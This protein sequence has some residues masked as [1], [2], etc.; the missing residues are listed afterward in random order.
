MAFFKQ[1]NCYSKITSVRKNLHLSK[2]FKNKKLLAAENV[3]NILAFD[4][5]SKR[6][7]LSHISADSFI[8]NNIAY[9]FRVE[10]SFMSKWK[11]FW[12]Q[13]NFIQI[14][15]IFSSNKSTL[16]RL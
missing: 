8:K 15:W 3:G 11:T 7:L 14:L 6:K 2:S 16:V 13:K 1:E 12:F 5:E 9:S 10:I 4:K